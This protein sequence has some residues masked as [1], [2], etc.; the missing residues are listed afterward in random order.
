MNYNT[1]NPFCRF[2]IHIKLD[3]LSRAQVFQRCE[4]YF[5]TCQQIIKDRIHDPRDCKL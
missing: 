1:E 3:E 2:I 5:D 4:D